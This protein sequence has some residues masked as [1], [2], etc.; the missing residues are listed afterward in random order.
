[1]IRKYKVKCRYQVFDKTY[2]TE[3]KL[4]IFYK[5][6]LKEYTRLKNDLSTQFVVVDKFN[7]NTMMFDIPLCKYVKGQIKIGAEKQ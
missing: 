3:I 6:A 2:K 5:R 7:K 1:M 4:F